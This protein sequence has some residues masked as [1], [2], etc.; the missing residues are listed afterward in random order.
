MVEFCRETRLRIR[1]SVYA[2]AYEM[3]DNPLV[4]DEEFDRLCRQVDLSKSTDR[5]DLDKWFRENFNH[6][7]GMWVRLHPEPEGLL[8]IYKTIR[9]DDQALDSPLGKMLSR[10][11]KEN[12][13]ISC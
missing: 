2:W 6:M 8:R 13:D 11:L 10:L 1:V 9:G 4:S 12:R 3:H 5:P 7:T